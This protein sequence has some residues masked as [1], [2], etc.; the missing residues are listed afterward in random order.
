MK[1]KT[2]S[3]FFENNAFTK[4]GRVIV[5]GENVE[6]LQEKILKAIKD[7]DPS[8]KAAFYPATGKI[9]GVMI[10]ANLSDL[11]RSLRKIDANLKAEIKR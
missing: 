3:A 9:V 11:S 8:S 2:Y 4:E 6:K 10:T 7:A 5:T 1:L